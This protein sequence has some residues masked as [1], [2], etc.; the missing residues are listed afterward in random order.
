MISEEEKIIKDFRILKVFN[1]HFGF[2]FDPIYKYDIGNAYI[3]LKGLSTNKEFY[4]KDKCYKLK[5]FS[6]CFMPFLIE[7]NL[8]IEDQ[9]RRLDKDLNKYCYKLK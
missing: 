8:S 9:M 2:I 5:Y 7:N 1:K 3:T 6:G 4:Y